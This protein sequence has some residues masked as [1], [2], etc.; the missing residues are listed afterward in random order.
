MKA[1]LLT[2]LP[3]LAAVEAVK[4]VQSN[5]DGWA[6]QYIRVFNDALIEAGHEVILS[7]PAE[8]KSGSSKF[9][10][11]QIVFL[12]MM[13]TKNDFPWLTDIQLAQALS[14]LSPEPAPRPASTTAAR[15]TRVPWVAMP[16]G[17]T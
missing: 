12:V 11:P 8:N 10:P 13:K 6:E 3:L 4:I 17:R 16:P 2:I 15:P 5:D 9:F 14:T 1:V 7:A